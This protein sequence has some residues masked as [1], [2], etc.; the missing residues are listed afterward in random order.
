MLDVEVTLH[1]QIPLDETSSADVLDQVASYLG[2][3]TPASDEI[4]DL[5]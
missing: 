5:D 3:L 4:V 1:D 2:E